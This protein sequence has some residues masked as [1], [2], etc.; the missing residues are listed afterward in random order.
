MADDVIAHDVR[1]PARNKARTADGIFM[2]TGLNKIVF[3][4]SYSR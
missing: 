4:I 2:N 3:L 1:L